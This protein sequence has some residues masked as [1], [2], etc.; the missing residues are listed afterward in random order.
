MHAEFAQLRTKL[1]HS[2][3]KVLD[4]ERE[5]ET[6]RAEQLR[7]PSGRS[8]P[9]RSVASPRVE[10]QAEC[11][12]LQNELRISETKIQA[13]Q[14]QLK[15]AVDHEEEKAEE[16]RLLRNAHQALEA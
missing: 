2:E 8:S 1:K 10:M 11:S 14:D 12:K 9:L 5:V 15:R 4:L 6:L 16:T 3:R 13:L 7:S